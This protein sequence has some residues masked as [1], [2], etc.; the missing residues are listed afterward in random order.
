M[1][2]TRRRFAV[3]AEC[4][5]SQT[6][7]ASRVMALR[8]AMT[9]LIVVSTVA[10]AAATA[11]ATVA[12]LPNG[13][14]L[15][16]QPAPIAHSKAAAR[17]RVFDTFFTNL[18]YG[19]GPIMTSNT[20][21]TLYWR[22]ATATAY[23]ADFKSGVNTYFKD[24]EHDS[25]GNQNVESVATQYN[26]SSGQFVK[27]QTAFGGELADEDPYPDNG[28]T[29]APKC[30]TDEQLRTEIV[31]YVGEHKLPTD[32][33]HEYFLLTPEGVE[34]CFEESPEA[35]C[36]ANVSNEE[37]ASYC[38]YHGIIHLVGG[39]M[40]VYAND[41]FVN[42]KLCDE[43]H[44]INGT[45]DSALFGGLS[46]EHNESITDPEPNNAWTDWGK[47]TGENGDKCR[48][49][50][51]PSEFGEPLGEV[52]VRG[53]KLTYNQEINGHKYW[54]QQEWS[55]KGDQCLQRLTFSASEAP[56]GRFLAAAVGV[57][58]VELN[59]AGSSAGASVR[60]SWQ[61]NDREGN[62]EDQTS[63]TTALTIRHKFPTS[64]VYT[65][66]LTV[67]EPDGTS[68]GTAHTIEVGGSG[69]A[70]KIAVATATPTAGLP[71]AFDGTESTDPP[72]GSIATYAWDF[73]DGSEGSGATPSHT[74]AAVGS[75]TATL[76]VMGTDG[77]TAST[78]RLVTVAAPSSGSGGGD[79]GSEAG[80]A[81]GGGTRTSASS[82]ST[83]ATAAA[84]TVAPN[85]AFSA[86]TGTF[87]PA[88][89]A[90]AFT[91]SVS[92]PG[93]FSWLA[94]FQNGKFGAFASS[95]KC[96][97]GF[98]KPAGKCR[99]AK[100]VFAKGRQ[101]V[102]GAGTVSFTL[103]P[104]TSAAKALKNALRKGKGVPVSVT[105]SFQSSRGGSPVSHVQTL[106]VKLES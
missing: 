29:R 38:A 44:H 104:S 96:K 9:A 21:Y 54:Y 8:V 60:Y 52:E 16:Y 75:Y 94:T 6:R 17:A 10:M 106:T 3:P 25:G 72:G 63:E 71:V 27:Y 98:I 1:W 90:I 37:F 30:L 59:V 32:M 86:R 100:I 47:L 31:K 18:D 57:N 14:R 53:K 55:N 84:R 34:S 50:E 23:P 22:P 13:Q 66:A 19:G 83:P 73:G 62:L 40:I 4:E 20:D 56:T 74:Y 61:F 33:N 43:E 91:E 97:A 35:E 41:P 93:T 103:K 70:A 92:D 24:L 105:L 5:R 82:S 28:C 80:G 48:T 7:S 87:A 79:G 64:G 102:A 58:E 69:P 2:E 49:F 42:G 11:G 77:L 78:T 26:D 68:I 85:S 51:P 15:S 99:P 76:T 65:V 45:S 95:S 81:T 39:G 67:F 101:A 36:S 12:D 46:H 89:G 88:T